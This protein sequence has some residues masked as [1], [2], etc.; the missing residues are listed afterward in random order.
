[1]TLSCKMLNVKIKQ[2]SN[3]CTPLTS[4]LILEHK[5]VLC[6]RKDRKIEDNTSDYSKIYPQKSY[7]NSSI[8]YHQAVSELQLSYVEAEYFMCATFFLSFSSNRHFPLYCKWENDQTVPFT[9]SHSPGISL[10]VIIFGISL[11]N[12][13]TYPAF[14]TGGAR[15]ESVSP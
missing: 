12:W 15:E 9:E 8:L 5:V 11:I 13:N 14:L 4:L 7:C 3:S 10:E 2:I 1:M 6:Y